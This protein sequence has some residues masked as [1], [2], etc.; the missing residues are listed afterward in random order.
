MSA[1]ATLRLLWV[2]WLFHLKSLTNSLFFVL[3]SVLQPIIFATIAFFMF[4]SGE[5]AGGLLYA[6]L[7]AGLMGIWSSTLFGSGGAIQWQRWQG[8]LELLVAA[9]AR[10]LWVMLPL[11][12]STASLGLYSIV[13]TLF[14]GR[15]FFGMPLSFERP[16]LFALAL[17]VTVLSLGLLGLVLAST[18]ILYRHASAFSNLLE[19]PV[20]LVTGLLVPLSLL[21]GWAEW[22]SWGL[23]PT[24]GMQAV[25]NAALGGAVWPAIGMCVLLGGLY[26]ALGAFFLA[27]FE[28]LA[29]RRATLSLT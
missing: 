10:F 24:W 7:G 15:V 29:R 18:F 4:R 21:P 2:G 6:A 28:R 9:P 16:W 8:T 14:W 19:Y 17:P 27:N 11:T 26:L 22:L 25:R 1:R 13:A 20:W 23:A 5:R 12:V 3:I